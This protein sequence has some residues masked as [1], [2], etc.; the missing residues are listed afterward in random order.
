MP[1]FYELRHADVAENFRRNF[2]NHEMTTLHE[3]GLYRH[4]RFMANNRREF[5]FD[6][7][8][9]PGSL[10]IKGDMGSYMFSRTTDMFEFFGTGDINPGYWAEK[11]PSYGHDALT[12]KWSPELFEKTVREVAQ[13]YIDCYDVSDINVFW[14]AVEGDVLWYTHDEYEAREAVRDF[15][16]DGE[17][18]FE[19]SWEWDVTDYTYQ[20][21]W[22]CFA[23]VHAIKTY[24]KEK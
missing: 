6:I 16:F 8:T 11:T 5:W 20:Y 21:L 10:V 14:A 23:I 9:W 3:D 19:D 18:I 13:D 17:T 2:A 7:I 24:N 12:K 4:L 22:C 1:G 15:K